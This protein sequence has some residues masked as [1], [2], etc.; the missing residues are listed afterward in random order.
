MDT[1]VNSIVPKTPLQA[2]H[3]PPARREVTPR[4][5]R[6]EKAPAELLLLQ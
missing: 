6:L 2:Y 4:L 3:C 1:S 5:G